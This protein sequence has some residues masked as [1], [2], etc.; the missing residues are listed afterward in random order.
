MAFNQNTI[1]WLLFLIFLAWP[2][3]Y[4]CANLYVFITPMYAVFPDMKCFIDM[5]K[6]GM[7]LPYKAAW[8]SVNGVPLR[9]DMVQ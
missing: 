1:I 4:V 7:A 9:S 5:L 6:D 3:G 2:V 8:N